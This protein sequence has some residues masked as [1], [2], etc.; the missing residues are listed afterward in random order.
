MT[1]E[2]VTRLMEVC[3]KRGV[4]ITQL[5]ESTGYGRD[6]IVAGRRRKNGLCSPKLQMI[7]DLAIYLDVNPAYLVGWS[8]CFKTTP[9]SGVDVLADRIEIARMEADMKRGQLAKKVGVV[10]ETI[11]RKRLEKTLPRIGM[12][13]NLADVLNVNPAWLVGWSEVKHG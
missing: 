10:Q 11:S 13:E 9:V 4:T 1:S 7:M 6:T 3:K 12:V 8:D 2:Y 5:S